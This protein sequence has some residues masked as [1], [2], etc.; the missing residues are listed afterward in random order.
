[1]DGYWAF[2]RQNKKYI[3]K[4][5]GSKPLVAVQFSF[6]DFFPNVISL[7]FV[8]SHTLRAKNKES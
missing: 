4:I 2:F 1:M 6:I 3:K 8:L 7:K 5:N